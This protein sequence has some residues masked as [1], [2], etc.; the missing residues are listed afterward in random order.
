MGTPN[1]LLCSSSSSRGDVHRHADGRC[2][3][4]LVLSLGALLKL[5]RKE[6]PVVVTVIMTVSF[7]S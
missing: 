4:W 2:D 7:F 1:M 3:L 6:M 5:Y